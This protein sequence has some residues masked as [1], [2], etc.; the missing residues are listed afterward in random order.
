MEPLANIRGCF[1]ISRFIYRISF[2]EKPEVRVF[3]EIHP[4]LRSQ[5]V[6]FR[7]FGY[8]TTQVEFQKPSL[9]V[10]VAARE[11]PAVVVRKLELMN[12]VPYVVLL[13]VDPCIRLLICS[14]GVIA[15]REV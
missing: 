1:R 12:T 5:S 15:V 14:G 4:I 2:I 11:K 6:L 9:N 8:Y 13:L 7:D 3:R 10:F